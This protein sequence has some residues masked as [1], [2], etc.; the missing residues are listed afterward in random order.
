VLF[1]RDIKTL[2]VTAEKI[3][4]G[5]SYLDPPTLLSIPKTLEE[6]KGVV[7]K[8]KCSLSSCVFARNA[9]DLDLVEFEIDVSGA[10]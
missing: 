3:H 2:R 6:D 7:S 5:K 10:G 4:N 1:F 8:M 9:S